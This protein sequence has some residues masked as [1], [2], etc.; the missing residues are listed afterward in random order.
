VHNCDQPPLGKNP[1]E[2]AGHLL[3]QGQRKTH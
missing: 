1:L 3:Y 2:M